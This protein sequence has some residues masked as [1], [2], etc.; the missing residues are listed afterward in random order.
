MNA[1]FALFPPLTLLCFLLGVVFLIG[2]QITLRYPPKKINSLYGYRTKNSMKSQQHWD[3][4]QRYSSIKMNA[5]G[6]IYLLMGGIFYFL[7]Y[8]SV[9]VGLLIGITTVPPLVLLLQTENAI[10][11]QFPKDAPKEKEGE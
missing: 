2:A 7:N 9:A 4:A 6:L 5:L 3:F 8:E 1:F 10:K 11:T